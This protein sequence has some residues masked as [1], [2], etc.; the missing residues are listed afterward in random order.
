MACAG[1]E[2]KEL[3]R[4]SWAA[5]QPYHK[6]QSI[7]G[8]LRSRGGPD[9]GAR[10]FYTLDCSLPLGKGCD[11]FCFSPYQWGWVWKS[12]QCTPVSITVP[13]IALIPPYGPSIAFSQPKLRMQYYYP[14]F[15]EEKTVAWNWLSV[16]SST[17]KSY[18]GYVVWKLHTKKL[19]WGLLHFFGKD[20]SLLLMLKVLWVR[21]MDHEDEAES[22]TNQGKAA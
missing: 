22:R 4:K 17:I 12:R 6:P 3:S 8:E 7:I 18:T 1:T 19:F 9:K 15:T 10:A 11:S 2:E 13:R 16:L 20:T 5:V 21:Y 14:R